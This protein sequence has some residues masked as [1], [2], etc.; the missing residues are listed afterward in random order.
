M[1]EEFR[2]LEEAIKKEGHLFI[3]MVHPALY[4][5]LRGLNFILKNPKVKELDSYLSTGCEDISTHVWAKT[6]MAVRPMVLPKEMMNELETPAIGFN[7]IK[8][9]EDH[10]RKIVSEHPMEKDAFYFRLG[11]L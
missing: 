4:G 11:I 7:T 1:S 8:E 10:I 2:Q 6:Q 5:P 3:A 9:G